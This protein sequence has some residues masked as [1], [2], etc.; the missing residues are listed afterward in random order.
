M[1]LLRSACLI[2][3]S[4]LFLCGCHKNQSAAAGKTGEVSPLVPGPLDHALPKLPTVTIWVGNQE[5]VAEVARTPSQVQTGMMFRTN[6]AENEGMLFVFARPYRA[7]FYMRNTK[8]PLSCAYIDPD[9]NIL[10]LHD[11]KPLDER[12][13]EAKSDYVMFVLETQQGWFQKH[14]ITQGAVV[15]T[16]HGA[17]REMDWATLRPRRIRMR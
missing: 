12:A 6:I 14:G 9:G 8:V 3:A 13:V 17:L 5:L 2:L 16:Q 11:L 1:V 4:C 15:R 7:S 10:E